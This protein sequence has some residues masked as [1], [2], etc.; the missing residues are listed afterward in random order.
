MEVAMSLASFIEAMPKAEL[1]V[2]LGGS[3]Q[4]ETLLTLAKRNQVPLLATS[5]EE[6][7]SWYEFTDFPHFIQVYMAVQQCVCSADDVELITREFLIGQATQGI[8]YTELTYGGFR[9]ATVNK[10][11]FAE[12]LAAINRAKDWALAELGVTLAIIVDIGRILEP[13]D[14]LQIARWA[15]DGMEH[16]VVGL[17]L[18]G[19]E[20]G[21][22]PA[23][24]R[25][26][27]EL[28]RAAGLPSV[29]HAGEVVGPES[30]WAALK[31][32]NPARIEHGVRCLEDKTLVAELRD[33]Q[34]PLDVC[35][36]SNVLLGVASSLADHPL[37]RMLDEGLLV[38]L[39][40]DD[41]TMFNT[42]L[43]DEYLTC[44]HAFG[45]NA[46]Q[47]ERIGLSAV[48]ASLLPEAPRLH[49][50]EEFIADFAR[51]RREHLAGDE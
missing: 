15:V 21:H 40:S 7:R 24:F 46:D 18:G 29:P 42:S 3:I 11:P 23:K 35:P 16:G 14:G 41:P 22:P 30:V 27:F 19:T 10:V 38:T 37:P 17:G 5:V 28:A 26:A 6:L 36:G 43:T 50:E 49:L 39:N 1:H 32:Q 47:I 2:H 20:D 25:K 48:R 9:L 45:W 4:P 51:L 33:R 8:R 13:E 12:Q 31:E 34:L 44:A